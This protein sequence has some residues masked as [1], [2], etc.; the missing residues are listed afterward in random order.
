LSSS[1]SFLDIDFIKDALR[2]AGLKW[3]KGELLFAVFPQVLSSDESI[4]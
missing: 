3:D 4:L 1:P 2:V